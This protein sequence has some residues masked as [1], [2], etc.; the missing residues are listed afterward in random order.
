MH[1]N[2]RTICSDPFCKLNLLIMPQIYF[3]D[4]IKHVTP[5]FCQANVSINVLN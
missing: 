4:V 3:N 2:Y 5:Q 1:K